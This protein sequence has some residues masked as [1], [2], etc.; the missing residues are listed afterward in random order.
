MDDDKIAAYRERKRVAAA[1]WRAKQKELGL[2]PAPRERK[3]LTPEQKARM[4]EKNRISRQAAR[5]RGE[6][7][8][9]DTWARDNPDRQT[10]RTKRW[11]KENQEKSREY[12]KRWREANRD[13]YRQVSRDAVARQRETPWGRVTS[14]TFRIMRHGVQNGSAPGKYNFFLGY[15]W[16]D[17]KA[18]I[19]QQF[20]PEM[21]WENWGSV[22][23]I[24][25][26]VPLSS[27]KYESMEDPLFRQAWSL[28][29]IRPLLKHLNRQKA[30]L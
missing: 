27:T 4:A 26:I 1:K 19:E 21:T 30:W 12:S 20:T 23:E 15:S 28:S 10:E 11:R 8:K 2:P 7:W 14:N 9:S 18:H 3:P 22:W 13:K 6:P 24:D 17:L 16:Q 25:H 5:D 29:N